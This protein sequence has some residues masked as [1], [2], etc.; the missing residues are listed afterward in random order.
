MQMKKTIKMTMKDID[1][2]R[3]KVLDNA[4]DLVQDAQILLA[5]RRYA[6]AFFLAQIAVEELGKYIML[7]SCA[8][9]VA[10]GNVDWQDFWKRFRHHKEKITN[11]VHS[12]YFF[13]SDEPPVEYINKIL[14]LAKT[15]EEVKLLALYADYDG[16]TFSK[17]I[18]EIDKT[19]AEQA[20][21]LAKR[22]VNWIKE[23]D[24]KIIGTDALYR[25]TKEKV[26]EFY[27]R[28]GITEFIER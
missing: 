25:L 24:K 15:Q 11:L 13:F 10:Y 2:G 4:R 23:Y 22:R 5:K 21:A 3:K 26:E 1:T 19:T 8:M 20:V 14:E 6:R 17:P 28:I 18:E 9:Q 7:I 27:K 12:E 16:K